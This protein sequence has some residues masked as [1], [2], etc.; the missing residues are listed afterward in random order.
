M[1]ARSE[2]RELRAQLEPLYGQ[3]ETLQSELA[4]L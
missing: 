3:W 1:R 4:A 2:Q